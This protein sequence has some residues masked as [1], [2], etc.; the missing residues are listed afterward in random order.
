MMF[1]PTFCSIL[2]VAVLP[3]WA[4]DAQSPLKIP[5]SLPI[6]TDRLLKGKGKNNGSRRGT[7]QARITLVNVNVDDLTPEQIVF[8]EDSWIHVFNE[9]GGKNDEDGPTARSL[10]VED[11]T[12]GNRADKGKR[13]P[14]DRNL[15][16]GEEFHPFSDEETT[17]ELQ[18]SP[19]FWFDIWALFETSCN[20]CGDDDDRR[21]SI[22]D[23]EAHRLFETDFCE[24]LR[25]GPFV[26][27]RDLEDCRIV[28][29]SD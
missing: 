19:S 25:Q 23:D 10:V 16:G 24:S 5:D 29:S 7:I 4:V 14:D 1:S 26:C 28:Y 12:K 20:L 21:L 27:F 6:M 15:R 17:R 9:R 22:L 13:R 11:I 18:S 2:L 8:F 3:L